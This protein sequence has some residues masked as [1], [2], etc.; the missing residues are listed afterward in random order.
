MVDICFLKNASRCAMKDKKHPRAYY[1][2]HVFIKLV[3]NNLDILSSD[4]KTLDKNDF[5]D[6]MPLNN[7][8]CMDNVLL[9]FDEEYY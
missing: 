1:L 9:I 5:L 6:I 8:E 4:E 7:P 3:G 2:G